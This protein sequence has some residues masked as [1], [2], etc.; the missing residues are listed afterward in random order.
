[1]F[2][3]KFLFSGAVVV[4]LSGCAHPIKIAPDIAKI[5]Q[6]GNASARIM[7]SVGYYIPPELE[8]LEVTTPGGGGD[9][10]RYY[11]Y[12]AMEPGFKK[13]LSNV[14]S[15]VVKLP[16]APVFSGATNF[17]ESKAST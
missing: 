8:S 9:N 13:M 11:P 14:F 6:N 4:I 10:V 15:G 12:R 5:E 17:P 16:A 1:M 2:L 7:A 3:N